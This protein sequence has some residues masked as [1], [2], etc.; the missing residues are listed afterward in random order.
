ME[1]TI[2]LR[3]IEAAGMKYFRKTEAEVIKSKFEY[4]VGGS[5]FIND[6]LDRAILIEIRVDPSAYRICV[7]SKI[8]TGYYCL[9]IFDKGSPV[10]PNLFT[11]FN[12]LKA[13]TAMHSA[14]DSH[15]HVLM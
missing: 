2:L 1:T 12:K 4:L 5:F 14:I 10:P 11:H 15:D 7:D 8:E 13:V 3:P 6:K 9:F